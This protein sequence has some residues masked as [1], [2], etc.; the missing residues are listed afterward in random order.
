ME[1]TDPAESMK[2]LTKKEYEYLATVALA[3]ARE[4]EEVLGEFDDKQQM[5]VGRLVIEAFRICLDLH[6]PQ[7]QS[8]EAEIVSGY[9]RT[10]QRL[11]DEDH[12]IGAPTD[13]KGALDN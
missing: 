8:H 10:L 13:P 1:E 5:L 12:E 11:H 7:E 3:T 9:E 2:N 6:R 4:A